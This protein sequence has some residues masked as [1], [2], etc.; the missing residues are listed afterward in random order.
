M[1]VFFGSTLSPLVFLREIKIW[2]E[3][4]P[5]FLCPHVSSSG[6]SSEICILIEFLYKIQA[7]RN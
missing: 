7:E 3:N 5:E 1:L 2:E 4:W 6:L